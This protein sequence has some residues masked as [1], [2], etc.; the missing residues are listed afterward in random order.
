MGEGIQSLGKVFGYGA[1]NDVRVNH[2]SLGVLGM[3]VSTQTQAP[4]VVNSFKGEGT[5]FRHC[6]YVADVVT[7]EGTPS[8]FKLAEYDLTPANKGLFTWLSQI[9]DAFQEWEMNGM[10][11]EFRSTA[12]SVSTTLGMGAVFM[13]VDYNFDTPAPTTKQEVENMEFAMSAKPSASMIMPIEC[14]RSLD[15]LTH[16][17]L[18]PHGTVPE[19]KD[20]KFYN[21]GRLYIGSLGCPVA[22]SFVGEIH[23]SFECTLYKPIL[24]A[25]GGLSLDIPWA[26][27]Q[28][29]T[30]SNAAPLGDSI[31]SETKSPG[32]AGLVRLDQAEGKIW[33][34]TD[35]VTDTVWGIYW[36][37]RGTGAVAIVAPTITL[38]PIGGVQYLLP[39]NW[40]NG[41][42][43]MFS[44]QNAVSSTRL[45]YM[46]GIRISANADRKEFWLAF[47]GSGTLP[48]TP[49]AGDLIVMRWPTLPA[50]ALMGETPNPHWLESISDGCL[51]DLRKRL[52]LL[53]SGEKEF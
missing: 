51:K 17:Y 36:L 47:S 28:L 4:A 39:S 41:F 32:A 48:T 49:V 12:S 9:T 2:N 3:G 31:I 25:G 40:F 5:T 1:Y 22:N 14:A 26:H 42:Q 34:Q 23:I 27:W 11:V 20:P 50:Y 35:A 45:S 38:D 21:L 43:E 53:D 44:P 18:G 13:A 33:F 29:G 8:A 7:G 46:T 16:L 24:R 52:R 19:G 15:A 6:E 30:L 37:Y 10:L